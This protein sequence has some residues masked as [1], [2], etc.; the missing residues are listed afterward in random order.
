M[1]L[2][3]QEVNLFIHHELL[4]SELGKYLL[5][6]FFSSGEDIENNCTIRGIKDDKLDIVHPTP[7]QKKLSQT[8]TDSQYFAYQKAKGGFIYG[9]LESFKGLFDVWTKPL[10]AM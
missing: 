7:D 1:A 3:E 9:S 2:L 5:W 10:E 4:T 6:K 8:D